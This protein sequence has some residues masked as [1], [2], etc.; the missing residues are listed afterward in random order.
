MQ[1]DEAVGRGQRRLD[2]L[3][4]AHQGDYLFHSFRV[5]LAQ[6]G[7]D[8]TIGFKVERER[9]LGVR[10]GET[11]RLDDGLKNILALG[12]IANEPDADDRART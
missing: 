10:L 2:R 4:L 11:C 8:A 5:D 12:R 1:I 9:Q 3:A 7:Q 6:F